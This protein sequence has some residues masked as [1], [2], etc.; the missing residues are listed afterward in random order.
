MYE[1]LMKVA[2]IINGMEFIYIVSLLMAEWCF[3]F[4]QVIGVRRWESSQVDKFKNCYRMDGILS[5]MEP[6]TM[7]QRGKGL[8]RKWGEYD[9]GRREMEVVPK[10]TITAGVENSE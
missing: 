9:A 6:N 3:I 5:Y 8:T 2:W 7:W 1:Y 4:Y 10:G